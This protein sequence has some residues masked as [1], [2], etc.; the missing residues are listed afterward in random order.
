MLAMKGYEAEQLVEKHMRL[1]W[2]DFVKQN[3][4]LS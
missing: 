1:S 3:I 2:D 4:S